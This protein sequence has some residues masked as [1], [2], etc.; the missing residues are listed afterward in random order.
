MTNFIS[1]NIMMLDIKV[2]HLLLYIVGDPILDSIIVLKL[3]I[4]IF[5][6]LGYNAQIITSI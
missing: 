5:L 2:W 3:L 1:L 6:N 4:L